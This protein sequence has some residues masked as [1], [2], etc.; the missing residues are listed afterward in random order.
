MYLRKPYSSVRTTIAIPNKQYHLSPN[1]TVRRTVKNLKRTG[2]AK[3]GNG[4]QKRW[5][6]TAIKTKW[7]QL[8]KNSNLGTVSIKAATILYALGSVSWPWSGSHWENNQPTPPPGRERRMIHQHGGGGRLPSEPQ[9]NNANTCLTTAKTRYLA[10]T[11]GSSG[12]G[13]VLQWEGGLKKA[14]EKAMQE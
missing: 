7:Q 12:D 11:V 14:V 3:A 4:N 10:R 5:P 9:D 2:T 8:T 13:V 1:L 6:A